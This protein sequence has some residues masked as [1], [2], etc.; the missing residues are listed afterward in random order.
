V[1]KWLVIVLLVSVCIGCLW[2]SSMV[3]TFAT[4]SCCSGVSAWNSADTGTKA[5]VGGLIL[6]PGAVGLLAGGV[7]LGL[8]T[9]RVQL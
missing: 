5:L 6:G 8:A 7:A 1:R 2:F 4:A 3:L 9:R